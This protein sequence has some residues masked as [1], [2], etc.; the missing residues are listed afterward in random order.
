VDVLL[1]CAATLGL[2]ASAVMERAA[3]WAGYGFYPHIP[4]GL[5][6]RAEP[7]RLEALAEVRLFRVQVLDR[8]I[9]FAAP[10]F[11]GVIRLKQRLAQT[12]RLRGLLCLVPE[13]ALRSFLTHAAAPALIDGARQNLARRW[14]YASAQL[15]LTA[16]VRYGFMAG[17]ALLLVALLLAPFF[18]QPWLLPIVFA[19]LVAPAVIRLAAIMVRAPP[20]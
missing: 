19:L 4:A 11:H 6:V 18:A 1:Y 5:T 2:G 8:E 17:L 15:E 9:A 10:D 13:P 7:T 12:P 16:P 14:P 3:N 20:F